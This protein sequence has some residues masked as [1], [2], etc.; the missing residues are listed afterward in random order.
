MEAKNYQETT[1]YDGYPLRIYKDSNAAW[2]AYEELKHDGW[3]ICNAGNY[4]NALIKGRFET[5][6]IQAICLFLLIFII[7]RIQFALEKK[8]VHYQ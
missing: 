5:A 1:S 3:C 2:E 7:T 6:C 8:V 4:E